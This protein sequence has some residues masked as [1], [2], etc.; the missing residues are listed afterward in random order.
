M[1]AFSSAEDYRVFTSDEYGFTMK[2]PVTWVKIDKPQGNY[3]VVFQAPEL[4]DNFRSRIHVAA[5]SPVK[6]PLDVFKQELRNG[7]AEIQGKAGGQ[8]DKQTVRILEEGDF[9]CEVPGSYFFFIQA[10]EEKI[11]T[12]MD[13]IIVFYKHEQTLL[14]ISCL[15]PSQSMEK[16]HQVFNDVLV[17]VKFDS[18]ATQPATR[19]PVPAPGTAAPQ[20]QQPRPAPPMPQP[21]QPAPPAAGTPTQQ[22]VAPPPSVQPAQPQQTPAPTQQAVPGREA[23]Q[24]IPTPSQDTQRAPQTAPGQVQPPA[25]PR[26]APRG[27]SRTPE[28][29]ATGIVN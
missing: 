29:P 4:V 2:Y 3:Y 9:K 26:P 15:A 13:I 28:G 22:P 27:P 16:F 19:P 10:F 25:G 23:Q 21:A 5:H 8:K 1:P 17:S 20:V 24:V 18:A 12:W 6:D 11:N 7:I 14:R